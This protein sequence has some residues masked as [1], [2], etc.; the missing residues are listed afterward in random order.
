[1]KYRF[2]TI[3]LVGGRERNEDF[4]DVQQHRGRVI[5]MLADGLGGQGDGEIASRLAVE[6]A[7]S[8][9]KRKLFA[10][11]GALKQAFC[12]A[13][14]A[15]YDARSRRSNQMMT[16]LVGALISGSKLYA[17]HVGD[18]RLYWFRD[19][20]VLYQSLDHSVSQVMAM[21]GEID[22]SMIR[23]HESRNLLLRAMGEK[24]GVQADIFS[25]KLCGGDRLLICSDGFWEKVLEEEMIEAAYGAANPDQWLESMQK[26]IKIRMDAYSDNF[27]A[28]AIFID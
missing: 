5:A 13:S 22:A 17:A 8:C 14:D 26:L 9:L 12:L 7:M 21:S 3:S 2:S 28:A 19:G 15:V 24:Q 27:T 23:G 10:G 20:K 11:M 25:G 18:S 1:M 4:T 16:T 6:S